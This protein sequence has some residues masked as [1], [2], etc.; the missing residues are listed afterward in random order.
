MVSLTISWSSRV[1]SAS[2]LRQQFYH[3][4]N[5][6]PDLILIDTLL[7]ICPQ[8]CIMYRRNPTIHIYCI[9]YQ[10]NP[11]IHYSRWVVNHKFSSITPQTASHITILTE[12]QWHY[13]NDDRKKHGLSPSQ[14]CSQDLW[15]GPGNEDG[16]ECP[17]HGFLP[18]TTDISPTSQLQ[19][20][21]INTV[22]NSNTLLS[23]LKRRFSTTSFNQR[24]LD[25]TPQ[26]Q[27]HLLYMN[28]LPKVHN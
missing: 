7:T 2:R 15:K 4:N 16:P 20:I 14:P 26:D 18:N 3:N 11:T 22:T 13:I 6:K 24:L 25:P 5:N 19:N 28:L 10:R 9:M 8:Y 12:R 1:G 21:L 27:Q 17:S 23:K